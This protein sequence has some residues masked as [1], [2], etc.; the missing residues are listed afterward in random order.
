M[1]H[2]ATFPAMNGAPPRLLGMALFALALAIWAA[3][4]LAVVA[5]ATSPAHR[6]ALSGLLESLTDW[7]PWR[8]SGESAVSSLVDRM[9]MLSAAILPVLLL[10]TTVAGWRESSLRRLI[11]GRSV[12]SL[13]ELAIYGLNFIG[14]W[15]YLTMLASFGLAIL[16]GAGLGQVMA[17]MGAAGWRLNTGQVAV[18]SCLALLLFT[19]CDYWNH[20]IQHMRLF[21]PLHRMHHSA[22]E[23]TVLTLWRTHPASSAIEPFL[24]VWPLALFDIPAG[25]V[26]AVGLGVVFYVHL[27]HSNLRW[28]WGW[29]G[30]WVLIPPAGH[31]LHHS[32]HPDHMGKNLG[33]PVLWDRLFGTYDP[34]P[35]KDERL[36]VDDAEYNTGNLPRELLRD[37]GD[38]GRAARGMIPSRRHGATGP[39]AP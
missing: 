26:S 4:S 13:T 5:L 36:G 24:K 7:L 17:A 14:L 6:A 23:M 32:T 15:K 39:A 33:I 18:D 28:D 16:V 10:E 31:R 34:G 35:L 25:I 22:T 12:S 27:A 8:V 20:R 1:R 11:G 9:A 3:M 21:W 30:R 38:F 19:F 37:L 2:A 29:F